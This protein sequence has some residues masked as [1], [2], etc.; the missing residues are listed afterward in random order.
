MVDITFV[1]W[2]LPCGERIF[3][4][5]KILAMSSA[6]Q[7]NERIQYLDIIRGFAISGV[8]FAYVFWNLGNAPSLTYTVFDNV[9]DQAGFFLVDSKCYTLLATMFA[10]G[11]VL[12]MNKPGNKAK[13]L[14]TYRRR[15]LGLFIIGALHAL[16]L[17]NGDILAPYAITAF[18]MTFVYDA[19]RA[20]L[21]VLMIIIFLI[22]ALLPQTWLALGLSFPQRPT[23]ITNYWVENFEWV[24]YWYT[25]SI[26]FWETTLMLLLGG[27]LIGRAF[28]EKKRR[29]TR[30]Q[31]KV[32]AV[33]AFV[34]GT[35]SY[36]TLKF[37]EKQIAQLPD[38][39]NS[40]VLR[41]TVYRLLDMIHKIGMASTYA[42][43]FYF[44]SHNFRLSALA[45][46]GRMS[47]T[48]YVLQ[49]AIVVP[50][51]LTFN[52]FDHITPT[53]ALIITVGIWVFQVQFSKWWLQTHRF[54][55]LE[56]V[57]RTFTY[58]VSKPTANE[59]KQ[60]WTTTSVK[61]ETEFQS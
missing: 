20:T 29:L 8:L 15:L 61:V 26:F 21:I 7:P 49:A 43:V 52:L 33:I 34:C 56:W 6:V 41:A 22:D 39:G 37:Y 28:I 31:I 9:I 3:T 45:N 12:H 50:I 55:P 38:I 18:L 58:G 36:L 1:R 5:S 2:N 27:I 35:L 53:I 30:R 40:M 14:Y 23:L 19:S 44:L 24:K 32:I 46:L 51:C 16:L 25:T 60:Q 4:P 13:N 17:R 59:H 54:G 48:N 47:L 11:F 42:C 57:L 10:V